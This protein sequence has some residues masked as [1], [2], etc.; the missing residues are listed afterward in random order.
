[1]D[2]GIVMTGG[3]ALLNGLDRLILEE[4]GMPVVVADDP[5]DSVVLGAGK[6]L[7][8]LEL[9]KRVSLSSRSNR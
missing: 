1:M 8:N 4:T 9:L 2:K 6:V 7:D 5:L 3:G